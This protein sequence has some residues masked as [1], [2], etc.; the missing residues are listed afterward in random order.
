MNHV[1]E[2]YIHMNHAGVS[3][4]SQR[5][6]AAIEQVVDASMNRP[7]RDH[8]AQDEADCVRELVARLIN[9]SAGSIALTRST[10]EQLERRPEGRGVE[11]RH[12]RFLEASPA[13]TVRSWNRGLAQRPSRPGSSHSARWASAR[14]RCFAT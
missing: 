7:Y 9:A 5:A 11:E 4:M 3:P 10:E 12:D 14:P 1:A 6:G 13:A 8:W 2:R